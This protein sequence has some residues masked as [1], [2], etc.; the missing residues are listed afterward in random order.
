MVL[1]SVCEHEYL[2]GGRPLLMLVGLYIMSLAF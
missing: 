2:G 1:L